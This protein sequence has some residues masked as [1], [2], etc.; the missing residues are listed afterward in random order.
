MENKIK[1]IKK[2]VLSKLNMVRDLKDIEKLRVEYLGRKGSLTLL[3]RKLGTLSKEER[4]KAGQLLNQTKRE[5]E[6]LL[7]INLQT[8]GLASGA[9]STKSRLLFSASS[10]PSFLLTTPTCL[11]SKS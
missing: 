8:G 3:L 1:E 11:P 4:P 9:T 7:K 2:E 5:I 6:E 10:R